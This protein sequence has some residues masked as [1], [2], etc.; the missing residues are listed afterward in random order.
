MGLGPYWGRY[1]KKH[2]GSVPVW[3]RALSDASQDRAFT[4]FVT[5][6]GSHGGGGAGGAGAAGGGA[7]GAG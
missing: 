6:S 2:P 4:A 3:F 5:S 7:S 1:I